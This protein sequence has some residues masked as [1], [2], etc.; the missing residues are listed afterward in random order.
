[1]RLLYSFTFT[2]IS[3]PFPVIFKT[4]PTKD[5]MISS[6]TD[7]QEKSETENG[8]NLVMLESVGVGRKMGCGGLLAFDTVFYLGVTA[9][10]IGILIIAMGVMMHEEMEPGSVVMVKAV[11]VMEIFVVLLFLMDRFGACCKRWEKE[12]SYRVIWIL[13]CSR[14]L[15]LLKST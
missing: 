11:V 4:S 5:I 6:K 1:M 13:V 12:L 3:E 10:L 9:A 8:K 2:A 14:N 7:S 15:R